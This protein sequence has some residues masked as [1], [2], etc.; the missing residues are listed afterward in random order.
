MSSWPRKWIRRIPPVSYKCTSGSELLIDQSIR[1]RRRLSRSM[2]PAPFM[3]PVSRLPEFPVAHARAVQ[4]RRTCLHSSGRPRRRERTSRGL[5]IADPNTACFS[6]VF[7]AAGCAW[8]HDEFLENDC[9]FA[10]ID[11]AD[12]KNSG[13]SSPL[14]GGSLKRA[15]GQYSGSVGTVGGAA[16]SSRCFGV[17]SVSRVASQTMKDWT[18]R[19]RSLRC[20]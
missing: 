13:D 19:P 17:I 5:R 6:G 9:S 20:Q 8:F 3:S 10:A 16:V 2:R 12:Q 4:A 7:R 15:V 14:A 11:W 1:S 18:C